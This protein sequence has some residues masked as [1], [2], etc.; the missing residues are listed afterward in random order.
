MPAAIWHNRIV[1]RG[2]M[3]PADIVANPENWRTHPKF[4]E[5]ALTQMLGKVGW[6]RAVIVNE[7][8]G[9]LVDGHL[10]V[11]SAVKQ[12]Q[13]SIP[14]TFVKLSEDEERKVLT[15][16]DPIGGLAIADAEALESLSNELTE[17]GGVIAQLLNRLA[18]EAVEPDTEYIPPLEASNTQIV[19]GTYSFPLKRETY[20]AWRDRLYQEV[21]FTSKDILNEIR[22]RLG[23]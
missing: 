15:L 5:Q 2:V 12:K 4:Q 18:D 20:L 22:E 23:L 21:G 1:R 7:T 3:N 6:V 10:R 17:V 16:L 11:L 19:I 9:R 14:V 8:T 13:K